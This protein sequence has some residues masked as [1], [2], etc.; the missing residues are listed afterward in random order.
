MTELT[1]AP[2]AAAGERL[3]E[4]GKQA[5]DFL[6]GMR[7]LIGEEIAFAGNEML[8]RA[9]TETQLFNEFISKMA[10]AHSVND[11]RTMYEVCGEH[12]I[13]FARRQLE[14]MFEHAKRSMNAASRLFDTRDPVA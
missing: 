8:D 6:S 3:T 4:V 14:H 10:Q 5:V 12:Q 2:A 13:D 9:Q 1:Q 7:R 11:I